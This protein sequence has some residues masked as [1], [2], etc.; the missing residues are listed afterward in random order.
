MDAFHRA[1][2]RRVLASAVRHWRLEI[3]ASRCRRNRHEKWSQLLRKCLLALAQNAHSAVTLRRLLESYRTRH[4]SDALG[5]WRRW[6]SFEAQK[7]VKKV[8]T[9]L[10]RENKGVNTTRLTQRLHPGNPRKVHC[11]CVYAVSRGQRCT[12]APRSHLLRRVEELHRLVAKGLDRTNGGY[13]LLSHV[14]QRPSV[15][16]EH[17]GI[18]PK[19]PHASPR[20]DSRGKSI[21]SC[22]DPREI[23]ST[24]A[25]RAEEGAIY[26]PSDGRKERKGVKKAHR[27]G[28]CKRGHMPRELA[29]RHAYSVE[30]Q[31]AGTTSCRVIS[32]EQRCVYIL[33][34]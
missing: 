3:F 15:P 16:A 25:G 19:G 11:R 2:G 17:G 27:A 8:P 7:R 31:I 18:S 22:D 33:L 23:E 34:L 10:T 30:A 24:C 28:G 14:V 5:G 9:A 29:R 6:I 26:A 12:C 32:H 4:L 20:L 21:I 13:R 1:A